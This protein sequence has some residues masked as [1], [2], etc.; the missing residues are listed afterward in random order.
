[1]AW[2]LVVDDDK[3]FLRGVSKLLRHVGH[4]VDVARDGLGA[5]TILREHAIELVLT[6]INMPEMD[7]IELIRTLHETRPGVGV[8]AVS[9]GGRLSSHLLLSNAEMLGADAT[10]DKPFEAPDLIGLVDSVLVRG[11]LND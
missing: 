5:L 1:M 4:R 3:E 6:D 8:I 11:K 10:L 9:G 7:G 2:I